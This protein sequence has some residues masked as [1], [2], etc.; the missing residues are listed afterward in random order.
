MKN[1]QFH[2][3]PQFGYL[4]TTLN[5]FI[6]VTNQYIKINNPIYILFE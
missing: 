3:F 5:A 4:K 6:Y 2:N 1:S